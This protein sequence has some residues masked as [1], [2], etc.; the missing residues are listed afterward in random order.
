MHVGEV[1][2]QSEQSVL[3]INQESRVLAA[4]GREEHSR[5]STQT[6]WSAAEGLAALEAHDFGVVVCDCHVSGV[7]DHEFIKRVHE[8]RPDVSCVLM[9]GSR[10][11]EWAHGALH[12]GHVFRVLRKPSTASVLEVAT[13]D[14][15]E[16]RRLIAAQRALSARQAQVTAKLRSLG[17]HADLRTQEPADQLAELYRFLSELNALDE[18]EDVAQ[19]TATVAAERVDARWGCVMMPSPDGHFMELVTL[20]DMSSR[21]TIWPSFP[22][23]ESLAGEIWASGSSVIMSSQEDISRFNDVLSMGWEAPILGVPL[24]STH[25]CHGV[26]LLGGASA[27]SFDS[28]SLT[29]LQVIVGPA[30]TALEN[31]KRRDERDSARDAIIVALAKL[32]E[33]RDPETGVHLERVQIYCRILAERL[34][35]R[36]PYLE[37]IDQDFIETIVRSSPLHDIG[38][39]GIPDRILLKPG[40]LTPDEY[41]IMKKHAMLGGD[42]IRE[43]INQG[44]DPGFL[45][46]GMDIA[47]HHHERYDGKGYPFGL[48]GEDIPLAARI[49]SVADVYDA[50]TAKRIYKDPMPHSK[51]RTI[52]VEGHGTQFDP[53]VLDAFLACEDQFEDVARALADDGVSALLLMSQ[54]TM[55]VPALRRAQGIG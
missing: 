37:L 5:Y 44:Q 14:G 13:M 54:G 3:L 47:Y 2:K 26:L 9:V 45:R 23:E 29:T 51:A 33:H 30:T 41:K 21:G 34:S 20:S 16:R 25:A 32:A 43:L 22:T 52:L 31:Q 15:L 18:L 53:H 19:L 17:Q 28:A 11:L 27:S 38:K 10:D 48:S 7:N 49:M 42:I 55:S 8:L 35:C 46:M 1:V 12:Q 39:V 36:G 50:L 6:A 4:M 40:R 24:Q